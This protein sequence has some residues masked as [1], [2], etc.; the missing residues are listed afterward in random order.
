MNK[1]YSQA[2][3][4]VVRRLDKTFQNFFR[5]VKENKE[6]KKQKPGYPRFKGYWRYDSF[7]YPQ[8]GFELKDNKLNLS[9]IDSLTI[10]LHREIEGNIKNLTIR[11]TRTNNMV[12]LLLSG[13]PARATPTKGNQEHS[14]YRYGIR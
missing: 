12:C 1:V 3:Q 11:R 9:K 10:K 5:R 14:R 2:L 6:G 4:D 8:L 13:N 7:T